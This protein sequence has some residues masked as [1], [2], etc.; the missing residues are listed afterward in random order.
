MYVFQRKSPIAVMY[1]SGGDHGS[2]FWNP[3]SAD[4]AP[5]YFPGGRCEGHGIPVL[6]Y[7]GHVSPHIL[8]IVELLHVFPACPILSQTPT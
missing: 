4:S 8:K 1:M 3:F 5:P 2:Y 6:H 7:A